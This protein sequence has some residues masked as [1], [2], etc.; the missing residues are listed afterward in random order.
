MLVATRRPL[1]RSADHR[2]QAEQD[3]EGESEGAAHGNAL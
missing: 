1:A 2:L 3:G